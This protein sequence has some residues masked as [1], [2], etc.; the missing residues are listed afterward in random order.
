MFD[1]VGNGGSCGRLNCSSL[2]FNYIKL[3]KIVFAY[4]GDKQFLVLHFLASLVQSSPTS[5]WGS[6]LTSL[7]AWIGN[8]LLMIYKYF[9]FPYHL[10]RHM[11]EPTTCIGENKVA[12]QLC[13]NCT[14]DQHPL[15]PKSKIA[16]F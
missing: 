8:I 14:A 12:D 6:V 1:M 2:R 7:K 15:L 10:S 4:C 13:I 5:H 16:S 9:Y 3:K 11:R